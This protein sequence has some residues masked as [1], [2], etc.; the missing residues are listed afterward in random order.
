MMLEEWSK[1][2][3]KIVDDAYGE[4]WMESESAWLWECRYNDVSKLSAWVCQWVDE[5]TG[6]FP[7]LMLLMLDWQRQLVGGEEE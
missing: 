3:Q 4:D 6:E 7:E 5:N 1:Q 2:M